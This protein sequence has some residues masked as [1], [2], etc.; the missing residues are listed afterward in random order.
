MFET[1][2]VAPAGAPT[3]KR[4]PV[5]VGLK[6]LATYPLIGTICASMATLPLAAVSAND[7]VVAVALHEEAEQ[8]DLAVHVAAQ[9]RD[10]AVRDLLRRSVSVVLLSDMN[11][12]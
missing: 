9:R 6:T 10:H 11:Y 12:K 4:A 5:S 7:E 2:L 3:N 8:L 1:V